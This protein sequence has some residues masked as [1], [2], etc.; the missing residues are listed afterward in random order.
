[1]AVAALLAACSS[2]QTQQQP[3]PRRSVAERTVDP[4]LGTSPSPRYFDDGQ[5]IPRGGGTYK[6]GQPYRIAGRW[7]FPREEHGYDR[8]GVGSWYGDDFHGR[9]TANGEIYDMRALTAAHPTL[10]M[11]SYAWVTNLDNGRTILV[12]IN[13]RGPYA[14]DRIIDL[15]RASAQALGYERKGLSQVRVRYA[16][17]APLDGDERRE[18]AH[19]RQQPWYGQIAAE[20]PRPRGQ[21]DR[22]AAASSTGSWW[23]WW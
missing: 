13:D 23:R 12:R 5:R 8:V 14:H 20:T 9:K 11:P 2:S 17:P 19:L 18:I 6:I 16:G 4:R 21:P 7:Y 15:S 10:P 1:M 22:S 3:Q